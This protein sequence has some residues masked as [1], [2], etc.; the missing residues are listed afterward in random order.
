M[1]FILCLIYFKKIANKIKSK[2]FASQN[3]TKDRI[4]SIIKLMQSI[5]KTMKIKI[6]KEIITTKS[7]DL[8]CLQVT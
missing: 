1:F 7:F 4:I 3:N 2:L 5:N 8:V 6:E